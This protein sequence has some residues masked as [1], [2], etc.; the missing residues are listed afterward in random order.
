MHKGHT[1]Y[2]KEKDR[3]PTFTNSWARRY[4]SLI[5]AVVLP[6]GVSTFTHFKL[7]LH[8]DQRNACRFM[9]VYEV[10]FVFGS[11]VG[12]I[13]QVGRLILEPPIEVGLG[14]NL[15]KSFEEGLLP[16]VMGGKKLRHGVLEHP[17]TLVKLYEVFII[18]ER[19]RFVESPA[20]IRPERG[21]EKFERK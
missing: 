17:D 8:K 15:Q 10:D 16:F 5:K 14:E 6:E 13:E 9:E 20:C 12:G 21:M 7:D 19:I 4:K 11:I 3:G 18:L 1:G 2:M